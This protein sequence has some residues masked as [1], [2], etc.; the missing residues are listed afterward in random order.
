MAKFVPPNSAKL[1][2]AK[3]FSVGGHLQIPLRKDP[4]KNGQKT[5][6]LALFDPVFKN[7]FWPDLKFVAAVATGGRVKFLSAV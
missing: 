5:L 4:L 7:N 6:I 3:G 2:W 1:F